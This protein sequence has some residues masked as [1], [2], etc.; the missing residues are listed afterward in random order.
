MAPARE[1]IALIEKFQMG[2]TYWHY[3]QR[4]DQCPYFRDAIIR[5]YPV[6]ISGDLK[7]YHFDH[8]K[9]QLEVAWKDAA[10]D[11]FPT[12]IVLPNF[13]RVKQHEIVLDPKPTQEPIL[14]KTPDSP[15]GYLMIYPDVAAPDR[16]VIVPFASQGEAAGN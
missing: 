13:A 9:H 6:C 10:C 11:G 5:P 3:G 2:N 8:S 12:V 7:Q 4:I 16:K 15:A 14:L 1:A